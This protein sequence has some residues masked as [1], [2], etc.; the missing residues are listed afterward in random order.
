MCC[1]QFKSLH[2]VKVHKVN[3]KIMYTHLI[4]YI[5]VENLFMSKLLAMKQNEINIYIYIYIYKTNIRNTK[6]K[7]Q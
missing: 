5:Q 1:F 3:M 2:L 7:G 4:N 6:H